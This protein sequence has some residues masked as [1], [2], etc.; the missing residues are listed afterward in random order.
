MWAALAARIDE[1]ATNAF[2][3]AQTIGFFAPLLYAQS[4]HVMRP[5]TSGGNGYFEA[6]AGWN[7]CAGLGVPDGRALERML[8]SE[9]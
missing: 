8:V 2:G 7:P 3:D 6:R 1:T 5:V 4:R 9:R